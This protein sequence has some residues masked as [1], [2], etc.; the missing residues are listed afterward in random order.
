MSLLFGDHVKISIDAQPS[1]VTAIREL[2]SPWNISITSLEEAEVSVVYKKKITEVIPSVIIP[3]D[4]TSFKAWAR[5]SN[6]DFVTNPGKLVFVAATPSTALS[7][8]PKIRYCFDLTHNS[9][10]GDCT[11]TDI[12][13]KEN[14]VVLKFNIIHEY[15]SLLDA[16]LNPKQSKRHQLFTGLPISY[17]L[18]PRRIRNYFM[19]AD[20]GPQNLSLHDKLPI[21]A[22]RFTLVNAIEEASGKV[23]AKKSLFSNNY[24]CVLTHDIETAQGLQRAKILKKIEEKYD[25]CSAWY[26]PSNRYKLDND[27]IRE[28]AN[29]GEIGS[30]DTKHDGKLV[31]LRKDKAVE[32]LKAAKQTLG[33]IIQQPVAGFRAPI[34]QHNHTL[35]QALSEAGYLYDTSIPT[36]EPKHPY[37]MN[38]HGIGTIYPLTL[39]SLT[40]IPLTLPQD[41][42]LLNVLGLDPDQVL[43]TWA[44]MASMIRD[45]GGV[46]MFLVHPDYQLAA[47]NAGLYEE[48]VNA[49]TYDS[50][51][52]ITVPSR[53]CT[54]M[55]E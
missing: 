6:L 30:H 7:I 11:S 37:T 21:D 16:T 33:Q 24:V 5:K 17:S 40:E 20:K 46:C 4:S 15:A 9:A 31:H 18:V 48:L 41:H 19:K 53:T 45:L 14:T 43:K 32:R 52:T 51:A 54:L 39:D 42:Q 44:V 13:P 3:S 36:W 49:V 35:L 28:L 27:T 23:L 34:L 10:F 47:G 25:I 38:S 1:D 26:V 2:L 55:N 12:E 8:T 50:Q 29:H 22:L